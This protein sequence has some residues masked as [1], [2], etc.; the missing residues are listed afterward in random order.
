MASF[1]FWNLTRKPLAGLLRLLVEVSDHSYADPP[2]G[3]KR[4]IRQATGFR[5]A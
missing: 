3:N 5:A 1:L 4:N 2:T